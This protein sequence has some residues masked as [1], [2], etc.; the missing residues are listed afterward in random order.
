MWCQLFA[1]KDS[2]HCLLLICFVMKFHNIRLH[3]QCRANGDLIVQKAHIK[4][5]LVSLTNRKGSTRKA[6]VTIGHQITFTFQIGLPKRQH[7]RQS[8]NF[9]LEFL[10]SFCY[11]IGLILFIYLDRAF[12]CLVIARPKMF[13]LGST[14]GSDDVI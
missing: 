12:F 7:P 2:V 6:L 8:C 4:L 9:H 5:T 1:S 14:T 13:P 11:L 10:L 3:I